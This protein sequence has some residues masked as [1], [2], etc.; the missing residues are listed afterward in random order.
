MMRI[1]PP[2][3]GQGC[4]DTCCSSALVLVWS[5]LGPAAL[6]ASIAT[7]GA[8]ASSSRERATF[9]ARLLLLSIPAVEHSIIT[10]AVETGG[11]HVHQEPADELVGRE[12]HD[13]VT[14]GAFDP[15]VLPFE[16]DA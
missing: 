3:Q 8:S 1:G 12:R 15:V 4:F 11:Q 13:A 2:Q 7:T 6:M 5:A 14:L 10:D 9:A 16:G